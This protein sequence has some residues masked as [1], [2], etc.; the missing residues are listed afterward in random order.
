V[1]VLLELGW[2]PSLSECSGW[3]QLSSQPR[4]LVGVTHGQLPQ[5]SPHNSP[6]KHHTPNGTAEM[7]NCY[8][9]VPL[10]Q[11]YGCKWCLIWRP[12]LPYTF[13]WL[14]YSNIRSKCCL[15]TLRCICCELCVGQGQ[16]FPLFQTSRKCACLRIPGARPKSCLEPK[17]DLQG[18]RVNGYLQ[19]QTFLRCLQNHLSFQLAFCSFSQPQRASPIARLKP[20]FDPFSNK[21]FVTGKTKPPFRG[22]PTTCYIFRFWVCSFSP[23]QRASLWWRLQACPKS[24]VP[25]GA[26]Y[27][28]RLSC[29]RGR[30]CSS[31]VGGTRLVFTMVLLLLRSRKSSASSVSFFAV[32]LQEGGESSFPWWAV[33]ACLPYKIEY[34]I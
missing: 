34:Q 24:P 28:W 2:R 1:V 8:L 25:C 4:A 5:G 10:G 19:K 23:F 15:K 33:L 21:H 22:P 27:S 18:Y 9:V 13:M 17:V 6:L 12:M 31:M 26:L 32:K 16:G 29:G 20:V 3:A 30:V 11:T 14:S 7:Y